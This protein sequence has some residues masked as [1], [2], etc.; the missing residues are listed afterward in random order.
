MLP[1]FYAL[2]LASDSQRSQL[3]EEYHLERALYSLSIFN[4]YYPM[5]FS[6]LP[7]HPLRLTSINEAIIYSIKELT[8]PV[9]RLFLPTGAAAHPET[10]P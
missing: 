2:Q 3:Q 6:F 7:V 10:Q 8:K 4:A 5:H 1:Q 9:S